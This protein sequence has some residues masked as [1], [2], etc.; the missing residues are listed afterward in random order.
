MFESKLDI[1]HSRF[2]HEFSELSEPCSGPERVTLSLLE[3][4]KDDLNH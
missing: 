2:Q 4:K 1:S 3:R